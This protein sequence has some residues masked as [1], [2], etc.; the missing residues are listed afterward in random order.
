[1]GRKLNYGKTSGALLFAGSAQFIIALT[2][3]EALYP[4]YSVSQNY[5]S[6]LGATCR[7]TCQVVQP[8]ATIFNSSVFLLGV[9]GILGAF[10]IWLGFRNRI[11]SVFIGL[12]SFGA[13]GVGLFPETAGPIHQV[14]SLITF[15]FAGLSAIASYRL[16]RIPLSY[17]SI[18]LGAMT[19]VSLTLYVS[20]VF[21]GLG[22]GGMERMIVYP[23][24]IWAVGFSAYL[25]AS[26]TGSNA[27][28]VH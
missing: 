18:L 2:V 24:L 10:S 1:M 12:A 8:T 7:A 21:L 13:M 14:V 22:Q 26:S 9:L 28:G 16:Q 6:D 3:A 15:V 27:T 5:I 19:L 20:N 23:A 4:N 11:L 25:V 17:F